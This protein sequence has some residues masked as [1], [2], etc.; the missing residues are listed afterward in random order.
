MGYEIYL[1]NRLT[2]VNHQAHGKTP[3]SSYEPTIKLMAA[4]MKRKVENLGERNFAAAT[5]TFYMISKNCSPTYFNTI[6]LLS[7]LCKAQAQ[8]NNIFRDDSGYVT[9][10][11]P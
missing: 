1:T 8:V 7:L 3:I 10:P 4:V 11:I 6:H 2:V 9:I 5:F